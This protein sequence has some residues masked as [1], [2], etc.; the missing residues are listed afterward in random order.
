MRYSVSA[1]LLVAAGLAPAA[2]QPSDADTA[3]PEHRTA[4]KFL[5]ENMPE[6]D[7][8]SLT[9]EFVL[10][11]VA[12]AYA[13][14]KA[15]TWAAA[16]PEE[17][18]FNDVLPYASVNEA[19]DNW[20]KDFAAKFGP[21]VKDCKSAGDAALVLNAKIFKQVNVGYHPTRRPKPDQS[22]YESIAA[23]CASCSGLSILLIDACRAV[24]VPARFVG[25]PE[26]TTGKGDAN[27]NHAGNHSWVEIWDGQWHVLGAIEVSPL[28]QTWFLGNASKADPTRP[29]HSIY[30]S[31]F[32][33]TGLSFPLVWDDE[34]KYV[35]AEDVTQSYLKRIPVKLETLLSASGP[36][37]SARLVLRLKGR[38][39]ADT[40][41]NG[42][43]TV[44]LSAGQEYEAT[45]SR[46]G[47]D[48]GA[49]AFVAPQE[50]DKT[51]SFVL[52]A[53]RD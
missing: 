50:K 1:T 30:A 31:S 19:R 2:L 18:F 33:K 15:S 34:I 37:A 52:H 20:R 3:P 11:N 49:F 13:A 51:I 36:S 7:L 25:T 41:W 17:V 39:I 24:G 32:R 22:P 35:P 8:Q 46:P 12:L 5:I 38:L 27:G 16:I 45:L 43:T 40:Q 21:L 47:Y 10:E 26:W 4:V 53:G 9:R 29:Q 44:I 28:S 23:G 6:R 14:R 42:S 48:G